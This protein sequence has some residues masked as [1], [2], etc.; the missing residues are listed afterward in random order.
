MIK[1]IKKINIGFATEYVFIYILLIQ[2]AATFVAILSFFLKQ[3]E[4]ERIAKSIQ[5]IMVFENQYIERYCELG[6]DQKKRIF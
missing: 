6:Q 1:T 5:G 2:I 4:S 3:M